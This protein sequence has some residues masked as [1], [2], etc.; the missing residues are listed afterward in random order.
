MRLAQ[1]EAA[2]R[3]AK[4]QRILVAVAAVVILGLVAAIIFVVVRAMG[5]DDSTAA[6]GEVVPPA[7]ITSDGAIPVG[8]DGAPV[9]VEIYYD[10]MCPACGAFEAA[11]G[12]ELD[13]LVDEGTARLELRPISFLDRFSSGTEYSTRSANAIATV[14]DQAPEAVWP[15]HAAL[16]DAQPEEGSSGLSDEEIAEIATD[17]GVPADV[18]DAFDDRTHE[19]WVAEV[20]EAAFDSGV[21]GTPTVKIDGATFEGDL[22]TPGVLT[23]AIE[24][25][26]R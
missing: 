9:S 4:Q 22:Y 6:G 21:E 2:R 5:G 15:F 16:Y 17:A 26:A 11:N 24:S 23:E 14:A 1:Q 12:D 25:A 8:Q 7:N 10:Y 3:Q 20:T 13:Q 18:V 19:G